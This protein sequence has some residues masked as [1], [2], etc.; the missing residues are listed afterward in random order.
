M[1]NDFLKDYHI[2][3]NLSEVFDFRNTEHKLLKKHGEWFFAIKEQRLVELQNAYHAFCGKY[4]DYTPES[5]INLGEFFICAIDTE[6]LSPK[7]YAMLRAKYP[8]EISVDD[9]KFTIR[10]WSLMVDV[11][12][13]FGEVMIRNHKNMEWKQNIIK[14]KRDI[15]RGYMVII[16]NHNKYKPYMN[17]IWVSGIMASKVA[18]NTFSSTGIYELYNYYCEKVAPEYMP[19]TTS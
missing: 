17:P 4:L 18:D 13:Y 9:F 7:E 10:S 3:Y 1:M 5:L 8:P 19:D 6:K 12:I 16:L 2:I 14:D 11:G 15:E